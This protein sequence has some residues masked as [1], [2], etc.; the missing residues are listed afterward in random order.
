[1]KL[2]HWP[3]MGGLLHLVQQKGDWEGPRP[4]QAPHRCTKYIAAHV[5][6]KSSKMFQ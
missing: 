3:M 2:V 1:M 5:P 6:V 4:V